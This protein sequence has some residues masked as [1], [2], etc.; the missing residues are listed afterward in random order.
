[1]TGI[2]TERPGAIGRRRFIRHLALLAAVGAGA[3]VAGACGSSGSAPKQTPAGAGGAT[4]SASGT[5]TKPVSVQPG[6]TLTWG[7][8]DKI[9][10]IDPATPT[11]SAAIEI[12]ASIVESLTL[13]DTDEKVYPALATKWVVE[14]GDKKITF[15]L[16]DDVKFHDG[17]ALDATAVKRS[18]ERILDPATKAA[19]VISFF[20]PIDKIAAPDPRTVV[21]TFKSPYPTFFLQAWR[22]YF[23]ILSNKYLDTLKPG[24]AATAPVGTGPFKFAGR[25]ADGVISVERFADY[26]WGNERLT[27]RKAALLQGAK[28]RAITEGATRVATLE[29][30]ENLLVD[31]L[32]EPD[33]QRLKG[34]KR[35]RFVESPLRNHTVG[36]MLN[37]TKAPTNDKAV[38]EAINWAVDRQTIVQ[39]LFFGVHRVSVGPLSDGIW[40]RLDELEKRY[41]FDPKKAQQVLDAAGWA[42]GADGIRVKDGQ[43]LSLA[44]AT[45]RSP[46]TE[47]AEALQGQLRAV[48]MDVQVQ[49]ME[50]G[51][52]LDY[53]RAY[54]HN[55]CATNSTSIDPDGVLTLDYATENLKR[56]N[57]SGLSDPELDALL[58][59][60]AAQPLASA[61]RRKAFEDAQRKIMDAIPFVGVMT[62]VRVEA[63]AAKVRNFALGP[64]GQNAI[65]LND[66]GIEG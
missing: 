46:W 20:G 28:F 49:K 13:I 31:D 3:A 66:V 39:K 9:D 16:R 48:G 10:S 63:M 8:W 61:E 44:L 11:G 15:T 36:F 55:L 24:D 35:F 34:D 57:F 22:P 19:G 33:Y 4:Q 21:V 43:R 41:T 47:I 38:R 30:G 26:A 56:T 23:G 60:G 37:V 32:P 40:G 14:D 59:N 5:T 42:A 53:V 29:S 12:L 64:D 54:K 51:A 58:K 1:M 2:A 7:L 27:N 45:F 25:S 6:G 17:T 65:P 62:L 52:Y 18:W 50:R